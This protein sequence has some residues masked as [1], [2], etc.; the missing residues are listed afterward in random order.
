MYD[1]CTASNTK[2][3]K[4]LNDSGNYYTVE[5]FDIDNDGWLDLFLGSKGS[6]LIIKNKE[7][8]FDR[9]IGFNIQTDN[10][11]QFLDIDFFDFD[12]DGIKEILVMNNKH[13][14]NGYY[15][16]LYKFNFE[17][18]S[19]ITGSYFDET[20]YDGENSWIKWL[21]IFDYDRDGDLDILADGLFG[22]LNKNNGNGI[23]YWKNTGEKFVRTSNF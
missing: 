20:Q 7:G 12:E 4:N 6:L 14:Y 19:D 3:R 11:L 2:N 17:S 22:D 1:Y 23:I 21:H 5:L 16:K 18:Y 9:Q 8:V 13:T 10:T 15:L